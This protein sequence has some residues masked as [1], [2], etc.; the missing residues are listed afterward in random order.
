MMLAVRFVYIV[1][2]VW[3][4]VPFISALSRTF[5]IMVCWILLRFLDD[6]VIFVCTFIYVVYYIVFDLCMLKQP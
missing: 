4:Y 3:R 6:H 2:I 1:F 5:I